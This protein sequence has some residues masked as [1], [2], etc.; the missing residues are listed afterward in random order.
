M[1]WFQ[2]LTGDLY[3]GA[4]TG[5]DWIADLTAKGI[6]SKQIG[7]L[8]SCIESQQERRPPDAAVLAERID[9]VFHPWENVDP[10]PPVHRRNQPIM[11]AR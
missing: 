7:L 5:L 2:F 1:I 11:V 3:Q 8:A 9:A 6:T 4:P 10:S